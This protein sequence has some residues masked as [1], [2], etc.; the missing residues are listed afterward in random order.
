MNKVDKK[1]FWST[2]ERWQA[3]EARAKKE[4][5]G[6][7]TYNAL[8]CCLA[9][10]SRKSIVKKMRKKINP[11]FE[12]PKQLGYN[13]GGDDSNKERIRGCMV[14]SCIQWPTKASL[15]L[16]NNI[17]HSWLILTMISEGTAKLIRRKIRRLFTVILH[18]HF[19]GR[20]I[21]NKKQ[22]ITSVLLIINKSRILFPE[23][24]F[25]LKIWKGWSINL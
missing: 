3:S 10:P 2:S 13:P 25:E 20:K 24:L 5:K 12:C 1:F 11:A 16:N 15:K 6:E 23:P 8:E 22:T 14:S 18:V 7:N 19:R 9:S 17:V 4:K 21:E